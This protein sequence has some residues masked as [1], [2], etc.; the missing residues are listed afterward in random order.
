[1]KFIDCKFKGKKRVKKSHIL[2]LEERVHPELM[3][4]FSETSVRRYLE[5]LVEDQEYDVRNNVFYD[6]VTN[7]KLTHTF[8]AGVA[9]VYILEHKEDFLK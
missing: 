6:K 9:V 3:F 8:L 2:E 7:L 5:V 1:M 4:R